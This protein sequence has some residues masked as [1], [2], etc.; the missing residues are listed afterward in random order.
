M[1]AIKEVYI[2]FYSSGTS[3][4]Q[5]IYLRLASIPGTFWLMSPRAQCCN[6]RNRLENS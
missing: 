6:G 5:S 2:A 1:M 4:L 3:T